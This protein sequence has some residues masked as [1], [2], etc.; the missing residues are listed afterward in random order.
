MELNFFALEPTQLGRSQSRLRDFHSRRRL[1]NTVF[2]SYLHKVVERMEVGDPLVAEHEELV[3]GLLQHRHP[4][5][6]D[7]QLLAVELHLGLAAL[8]HVA[9]ELVND[10]VLLLVPLVLHL[11]AKIRTYHV[12]QVGK[13]AEDLPS[14]SGCLFHS[15]LPSVVSVK[16][17]K[18]SV[19]EFCLFV[20]LSF[21]YCTANLCR[22][23]YSTFTNGLGEKLK[24]CVQKMVII[25]IFSSLAHA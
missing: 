15:L 19:K 9:L 14:L 3:V 10:L 22:G 13:R 18:T 20:T 21:A 7:L 1:H 16:K 23:P 17:K 4:L 12:T 2:F 25:S 5:P 11:T 8:L 24:K 6:V